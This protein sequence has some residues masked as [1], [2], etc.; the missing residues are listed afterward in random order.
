MITQTQIDKHAKDC[1]DFL[2]ICPKGEWNKEPARLNWNSN[3][4]DCLMV[5]HPSSGH[6]CGYVGVKPRHPLFGK[7]YDEAHQ[8]MDIS[9]H[10]G[11]TYANSCSGNVC[12]IADDPEDNTWWFGFDCHHG[13]DLSPGSLRAEEKYGLAPM[14]GWDGKPAKYRNV[15]F[16]QQEVESLASQ[17]SKSERCSVCGEWTDPQNPCCGKGTTSNEAE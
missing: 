10:G 4:F 5:R 13:G 8:A 6:W 2:A 12:H 16:V 9:V 7:S 14:S 3:G 1:A 11:L 15:K 17:L